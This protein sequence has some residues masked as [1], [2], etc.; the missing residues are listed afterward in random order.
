MA[1]LE[2]FLPHFIEGLL[3]LKWN[4]KPDIF[5]KKVTFNDYREGFFDAFE[6]LDLVEHNDK[7]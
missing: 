3:K 7:V 1:E 5:K 2:R 4:S 6:V